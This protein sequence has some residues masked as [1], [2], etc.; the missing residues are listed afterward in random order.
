MFACSNYELN[1]RFEQNITQEINEN[2]R[3]IR[4]HASL[5]LWCGNNEIEEFEITGKY[6]SDERT[7]A[8][9]IKMYEYLIPHILKDADP[10]TPYWPSSPSSGGSFD[11]PTDPS[12]GDMHY[13]EVWHGG[14]PFSTYRNY[15]FRYVS[16][17]GFQS[18]PDMKTITSFTKPE[19]RNIFSRI[20]DKHQRNSSANGRI[21]MYMAQTFRYPTTLDTLVYASQLLQ[22]EAIKYGVEHWRRN[23]GVC[24]GAIYWQLDDIW[25]VAS[26]S[27]IDYY[28]RWK[29]LH[30]FARRFFA[31][32][33]ISCEETGE[34][35]VLANVNQE[36]AGPI[37][38]KGRF[39]IANETREAVFGVV[40]WTLRN[41]S[42]E[43]LASGE[44]T[45]K[46]P[47]LSSLWL[48][49]LDFHETDFLHN[50]L[51]YQWVVD[52]KVVSSGSVLFTQP[53]Y[54]AFVDPHLT[55]ELSGNKILVH[56]DAYA[57]YVAIDS[58][59]ADM[60]LSDNYFDMEKGE[61][62]IRIESG[63]PKSLRIRSCFDIR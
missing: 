58:P 50:H 16:E 4:H 18:F 60:R 57:K 30:Y 38:T 45:A 11:H 33:I 14:V 56:A 13:W 5:G 8:T 61:R 25:P 7:R 28:G 37:P 35:T 47:A 40:R 22:A 36:H 19:D 44:E 62:E 63:N 52:G 59:D 43:V 41:G 10:A 39:C 31:P 55:C 54:Y 3:R 17:F 53:K 2:V 12:R 24:M 6:E 49:E 20:M 29:A 32:V 1:D 51:S 15:R 9:Y 26:W 21:M 23:R 48:N 34:Q 27:S 46:V 42:S